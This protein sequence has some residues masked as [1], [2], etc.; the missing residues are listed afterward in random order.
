MNIPITA[1]LKFYSISNPDPLEQEPVLEQGLFVLLYE[2][3]YD[4]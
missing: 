1:V 3:F 4:S 2:Y